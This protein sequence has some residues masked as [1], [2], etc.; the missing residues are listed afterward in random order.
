[1]LIKDYQSRGPVGT[2]T[3][4]LR[5]TAP[6]VQKVVTQWLPRRQ[7]KKDLAIVP[8]EPL[9]CKTSR[10]GEQDGS[11]NLPMNCMFCVTSGSTLLCKKSNTKTLGVEFCQIWEVLCKS[12]WRKRVKQCGKPC[13]LPG[14]FG[15]FVH[16]KSAKSD[17]ASLDSLMVMGDDVAIQN[18]RPNPKWT[19][20]WMRLV[21]SRLHLRTHGEDLTH[22]IHR[23]N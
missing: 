20:K 13:Q 12:W 8:D 1:M 22:G 11:K 18:V 21:T 4:D 2:Y 6:W 5:T 10:R 9:E 16:C 14:K 23:D 7:M 17:I 3:Y 19:P 15:Q